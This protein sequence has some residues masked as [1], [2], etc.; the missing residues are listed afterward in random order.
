M[1]KNLQFMLF[2]PN[3]SNNILKI[4]IRQPSMIK[5][6]RKE[7]WGRVIFPLQQNGTMVR[8]VSL[9]DPSSHITQK[10]WKLLFYE[11]MI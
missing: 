9:L 7:Q 8:D 10:I 4:H 2:Q 3:I 5:F 1:W 11:K 6:E